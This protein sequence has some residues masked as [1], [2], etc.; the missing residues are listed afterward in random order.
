MWKNLLLLLLTVI[1]LLLT[2]EVG[3][4]IVSNPL[5]VFDEA[6][7]Y[8]LK[9]GA[10]NIHKGAEFEA[11]YHINHLGYRG[12]AYGKERTPGK[13]RIL[14]IG[15]SS[16]FGWGVQDREPFSVLLEERLTDVEVVNLSVSGYGTDQEYLRLKKDGMAY[17]PD[18]VIIQVSDNDFT[19]I[20]MPIMYGRPKPFF[21]LRSG[22][23]VLKNMPVANRCDTNTEYYAGCLPLPFRDWLEGNSRFYQLINSRY[24]RLKRDLLRFFKHEDAQPELQK[25]PLSNIND[26]P[27]EYDKD[28]I[29]LF[30]A[31]I[32]EIKKELYA[33]RTSLVM[34]H[35]DKHL[36][37]NDLLND[38]GIPIIDLYPLLTDNSDMLI[39][40]D[41]HFNKKGHSLVADSI[42][43]ELAR[44]NLLPRHCVP[45]V[46]EKGYP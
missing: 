17:Q 10:T 24:M 3:V 44:K 9:P 13:F 27:S 36:S 42:I 41:W 2:F 33:K 20:K 25:P 16:G 12:K 39:P 21:M 7:G 29:E 6:L 23:L 40:K 26:I 18:L 14:L 43:S 1:V 4:R 15:D 22:N 45:H 11:S 28:S 19:E 30:K 5:Y 37:K 46:T 8:V 35:W 32:I 34:I 31:I 38:I